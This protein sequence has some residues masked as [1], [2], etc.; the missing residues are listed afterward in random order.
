MRDRAFTLDPQRCKARF[1]A[2][3]DSPP[4]TIGYAWCLEGGVCGEKPEGSGIE[5]GVQ[6]RQ[7]SQLETE[8]NME[9]V[10]S[11]AEVSAYSPFDLD[12]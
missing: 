1:H 5:L 11:S 4:R 2:I 6:R 9:S 12:P 8:D 3:I 7:R 10:I